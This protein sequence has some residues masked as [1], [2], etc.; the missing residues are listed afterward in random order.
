MCDAPV[1]SS[2]G[3]LALRGTAFERMRTPEHQSVA[4]EWRPGAFEGWKSSL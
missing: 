1:L 4:H 2:S 3:A